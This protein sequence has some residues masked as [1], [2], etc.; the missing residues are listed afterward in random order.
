MAASASGR[1]HHLSPSSSLRQAPDP[2]LDFLVECLWL[3]PPLKAAVTLFGSQRPQSA[4]ILSLLQLGAV[5][6]A[7]ANATEAAQPTFVWLGGRMEK[8]TGPAGMRSASCCQ[9]LRMHAPYFFCVLLMWQKQ[10]TRGL[11][12]TKRGIFVESVK[13]PPCWSFFRTSKK[14]GIVTCF[15]S[16]G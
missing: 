14:N 7:T 15:P 11:Q 4:H 3:P 10:S 16:C 8:S 1:R 2:R 5:E 6:S 12:P 13:Y 9:V